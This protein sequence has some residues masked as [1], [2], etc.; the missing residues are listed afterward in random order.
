MLK[1]KWV[2]N[3]LEHKT[4]SERIIYEDPDTSNG[5]ILLPDMKWDSRVINNLYALAICHR[6]GIR[7]IRD[8]DASHI[9]LLENIR[10]RSLQAIEDR[11]GIKR[12]QVRT[13]IHYQ[14]TFYHLH[15]HVCH[16]KFQPPGIPDRNYPLNNVIEN[17]KIDSD[18]YKKATLEFVLKQNEKLYDLYKHK[19]E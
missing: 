7:S 5:F 2:F 14:P 1:S 9:P 12:A 6:R 11:F 8:L 10:D 4:E 16:I 15:V 17:L 3:I 19:L 18:Y 13:Y